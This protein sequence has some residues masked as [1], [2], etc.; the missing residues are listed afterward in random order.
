M[1]TESICR[2]YALYYRFSTILIFVSAQTRRRAQ[3]PGHTRIK[4]SNAVF[5]FA[6]PLNAVQLFAAAGQ[7]ASM[8]R[9]N[10]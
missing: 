5:L 7:R 2:D 10:P 9:A 8:R 1:T 6:R 3:L 4:V